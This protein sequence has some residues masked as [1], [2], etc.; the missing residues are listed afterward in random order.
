MRRRLLSYRLQHLRVHRHRALQERRSLPPVR[1]RLVDSSIPNRCWLDGLGS[2]VPALNLPA[3]KMHAP[4]QVASDIASLACTA[5]QC[6]SVFDKF[7]VGWSVPM[8]QITAVFRYIS[9]DM[10]RFG[11]ACFLKSS[12]MFWQFRANCYGAG[13]WIHVRALILSFVP[14]FTDEA[15]LQVFFTSAILTCSMAIQCMLWYWRGWSVMISMLI[16]RFLSF[17]NSIRARFL[18]HL[19]NVLLVANMAGCWITCSFRVFTRG[20]RRVA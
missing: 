17:T 3:S 20:P 7:H 5:I 6:M 9:F 8:S 19:K 18:P 1:G 16:M 2:L 14:I 10:G 4:M 13:L 11:V 12:P 15:A